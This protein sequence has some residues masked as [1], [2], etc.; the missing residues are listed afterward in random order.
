MERKLEAEAAAIRS[1][2]NEYVT[3]VELGDIERYARVVDHE[4]S[5]V[6]FGTDVSERIV[7]WTALKNSMETQFAGLKNTRIEVGDVTVTITPEGG[8]AWA[9]SM[10][11]FRATAGGQPMTLPVRCSWVL[12]RRGATWTI[13]HFHKSVGTTA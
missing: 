5:M 8:F 2:L 7:G 10:W 11:T 13:V 12:A 6:N 3:A 4:P 9:T 1:V